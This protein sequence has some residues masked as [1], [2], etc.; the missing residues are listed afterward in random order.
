MP[1]ASARKVNRKGGAGYVPVVINKP[2]D[3]WAKTRQLSGLFLTRDEAV[4]RAQW[5]IDKW[6]Q[7]M[8]NLR[9][10]ARANSTAK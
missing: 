4:E 10:R 7:N 5:Q 1:K 3:K 2:G 9:A 8:M 6:T